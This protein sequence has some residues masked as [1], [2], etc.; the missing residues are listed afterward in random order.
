M[1]QAALLPLQMLQNVSPLGTL[2]VNGAANAAPLLANFPGSAQTLGGG[3]L[4]NSAAGSLASRLRYSP[5]QSGK[6][7]FVK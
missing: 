3:A 4:H 6:F 1:A 7:Y 5:Y 2:L